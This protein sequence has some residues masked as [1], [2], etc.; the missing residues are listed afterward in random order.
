M[1]AWLEKLGPWKREQ[2]N[3]LTWS[4]AGGAYFPAQRHSQVQEKR[5]PD[6]LVWKLLELP[7]ASFPISV[8]LPAA[9][10]PS[11]A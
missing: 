4:R 2:R 7:A 6:G 8:A 1:P 11:T 5:F 10:P 3:A 9:D